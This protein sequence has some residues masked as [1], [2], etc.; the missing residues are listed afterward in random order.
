MIKR[1]L[2]KPLFMIFFFATTLFFAANLSRAEK[3]TLSEGSLMDSIRPKVE[4]IT[5]GS[6]EPFQ[7]YFSKKKPVTEMP[8]AEITVEDEVAAV[9]EEPEPPPSLPS[10]TVQ[11]IIWGGSVPCAIINNKVLKRGDSIEE[12][13]LIKIEKE[14]IEV[15]YQ[16]WNYSLSSPANLSPDEK[17]KGGEDE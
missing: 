6:R 10:L 16:G 14:S 13:E 3:R 11:G 2:K 7:D 1:A 15:L 17:P 5:E 4:Y 12:V 8:E 9:P